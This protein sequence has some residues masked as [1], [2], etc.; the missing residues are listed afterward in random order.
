[1][2]AT[3]VAGGRIQGIFAEQ[4]GVTVKAMLALNGKS[5]LERTME[6]FRECTLV[7]KICVVGPRDVEAIARRAG[8][9]RFVDE[10]STGIDNVMRG[11]DALGAQ[12]RVLCSAS[13][14]PFL[15][16]EDIEN[17]IRLTPRDAQLSYAVFSRVEWQASFRGGHS[18]F[19]PFS[20]G[21]FT[22]GCVFV[23]DAALLRRIEPVLQRAFAARKSVTGMAKLFGPTLTL[24]L[25]VGRSIHRSLGPSTDS[26]RR[27]TESMLGCK[28]AVV[29]GCSPRLAADVDDLD[30]W[31]AARRASAGLA[32]AAVA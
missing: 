23:L 14:L 3:V 27:R 10:G 1:M 19:I 24:R 20:D 29:R 11:I 26:V 8:A 31:H 2:N 22:G 12:G 28:C 30:D 6:P 13:D 17:M 21:E 18:T 25:I 9:D 32:E 7:G 5:L 15:R 16:T 4:E